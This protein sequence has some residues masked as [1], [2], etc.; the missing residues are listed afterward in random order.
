MWR[1]QHWSGPR[2]A[3]NR[4]VWSLNKMPNCCGNCSV[5]RES[6][7]S[8]VSEFIR[9]HT[10]AYG[11]SAFLCHRWKAKDPEIKL[12]SY[13]ITST[14]NHRQGIRQT[15][16]SGCSVPSLVT[17]SSRIKWI[18]IAKE[19]EQGLYAHTEI[20]ISRLTDRNKIFPPHQLNKKTSF[21]AGLV[22]AIF[23]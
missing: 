7:R 14:D 5:T 8:R 6:Q 23:G 22:V 21:H 12:H 3:S 10:C 13:H 4:V 9:P 11:T 1:A 17:A 18:A 2:A 15:S 19:L 20:L 16:A